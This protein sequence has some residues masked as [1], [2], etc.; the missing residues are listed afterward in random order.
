MRGRGRAQEV[1]W[2]PPRA[3]TGAGARHADT[4]QAGVG[5]AGQGPG[6]LGSSQEACK[7]MHLAL[8]DGQTAPEAGQE[9]PSWQGGHGRRGHGL[10]AAPGMGGLPPLSGRSLPSLPAPSSP[11]LCPRLSHSCFHGH[12]ELPQ[13]PQQG[14]EK[15]VPPLHPL[16]AGSPAPAHPLP[17]SCRGLP[18]GF[19]AGRIKPGV[20]LARMT[21]RMHM[22]GHTSTPTDMHAH[23]H[24]HMCARMHMHACTHAHMHIHTHACMHAHIHVHS[25]NFL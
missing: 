16:P 21:R 1:S 2:H 3:G 7:P 23:T 10:A 18:L 13:Q 4:S 20:Y 17:T 5:S 19:P 6:E 8:G 12:Q 11:H 25:P 9:H 15:P 24:P 22:H 14:R